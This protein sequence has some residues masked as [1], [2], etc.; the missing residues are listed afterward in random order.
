MTLTCY[1]MTLAC[2]TVIPWPWHVLR[3]PWHGWV[4]WN[5][6]PRI[7]AS[8]Q[9]SE[10]NTQFFSNLA[11]LHPDILDTTVIGMLVNYIL[12]HLSRVKIHHAC[13]IKY[14]IIFDISSVNICHLSF[15]IKTHSQTPLFTSIQVN[16]EATVT[17]PC[18][19]IPPVRDRSP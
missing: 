10:W 18:Y 14:S 19:I 4:V 15:I 17:P 3:W 9:S 6:L 8:N 5:C 12:Q 7:E 11:P 16:I 1:A 2:Y 13:S